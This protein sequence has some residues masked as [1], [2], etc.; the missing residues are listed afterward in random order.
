MHGRKTES[1]R[2]EDAWTAATGGTPQ[3]VMLWG[4]RRMGK[5]LLASRFAQGKRAVFYGATRQ[6]E[7]V[8]LGR[9]G[10]AVRRGLG[11]GALDLA[12]GSLPSWE[13][14]LKYFAAQARDEPL[15]VVLDEVPYL[16]R[17]TPGFPSIVQVVWDH[18]A[19]GT[20]LMLVLVGSAVGTMT[21]M[22]G[23]GGA[24]L[25]RPTMR[26]RLDP[27]DLLGSS[28]FL[29]TLGPVALLE[30]YA[31]CGGYP[32]HLLAW[33]PERDTRHNLLQL[34]GRAGGMLL[35][36]A[37]GI[38]REELPS[39]G[40]YTRILAAVGRG[41]S[42]ASD[43]AGEAEQRIEHPMGVLV[44]SGFVRRGVPVGAPRKARPLYAIDDA[45]LAFWFG[46]LFSDRTLIEAGQAEAVFDR[47]QP[48]WERHLG[49]VFEE[50]A[51]AHATRLVSRGE[52]VVPGDGV[53]VGRW[54]ASSGEAC[55]IDVLAL[56]GHTA[57]LLG[58]ARWQARPLGVR[59][60]RALMV[61]TPRAP[62][63]P[64]DPVYALWGRNGIDD[65][66]RAAGAVGFNLADMLAG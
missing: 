36:D 59:E 44:G 19:A 39:T 8:E 40:G 31:A 13:A 10:V 7:E 66:A 29:P 56:R 20:K 47:R 27:F 53:V 52:L 33:D 48:Q 16:T 54:W 37:D 24:L 6:S 5:T 50:A 46:V 65:A 11:D 38:L 35:D 23:A 64:E 30:A 49:G 18:L 21:A 63:S 3:L 34:A 22:L 28:Q 43:I 12:G 1:A 42:R 61:K 15:V 60:L 2:L 14:A 55:E 51:R 9:L 32:M 4:R 17:S 45:Y 58:E 41:R 26:M 25:G 62:G 57:A